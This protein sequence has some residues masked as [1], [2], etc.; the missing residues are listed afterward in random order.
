MDEWTS[1]SNNQVLFN[2][3]D[4][5][6]Y[7]FKIKARNQKGV[8]GEEY[9][10]TFTIK[11]PLWKSKGAIISYIVM[12]IMLVCYNSTKVKRLDNLVAVTAPS[13]KKLS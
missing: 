12:I 11:P 8:M 13:P 1:T 3:L 9:K 7:T 5:G 6:K 4:P 10:V 2:K